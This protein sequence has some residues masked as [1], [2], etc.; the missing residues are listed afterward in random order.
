MPYQFNPLSGKIEIAPE[1]AAISGVAQTLT[2]NGSSLGISAGNTVDLSAIDTQAAAQDLDSVLNT[3]NATS[4][5]AVVGELKTDAISGSAPGATIVVGDLVNSNQ[6]NVDV[7]GELTVAQN[8]GIPTG[9]L[10]MTSGN[11][12][13]TN[14]NIT[15]TNGQ[16]NGDGSGL[17][18]LNLSSNSLTDLNI[19]DG[20]ANTFLRAN[21]NGTFSFASFSVIGDDD[22][23]IFTD[24]TNTRIMTRVNGTNF[25][26][27]EEVSGD[28]NLRPVTNEVGNLGTTASQWDET[29]TKTI[30][31]DGTTLSK[32]GSGNLLWDG[33][34]VS[35][36]GAAAASDRV[37]EGNSSIEVTDTGTNGHID[38]T[39]EGTARWEFTNQGHLLPSTNATYDIGSAERKVR[40]LFLDSNTMFVGD[41]P[42]SEDNIDR[43][44]EVYA[45]QAAPSSA[46]D[47]GKKG[48]VRVVDGYMYVCTDTDTWVRSSI[49]TSW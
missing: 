35:V 43:S 16:F 34:Q 19:A 7:Q 20:A 36:G 38:I 22:T 10:D 49:E 5:T 8:I 37:E 21:G 25:V 2:L 13:N 15:L 41:T 17:S 11:I 12:T 30:N 46:S 1:N 23:Q 45:D 14:G 18:N 26:F 33:D 27:H 6:T 40:Y 44:M 4:L 48:D 28:F 24:D 39:T 9:N 47:T 29:H 32:D 42:F 31:I 3:G